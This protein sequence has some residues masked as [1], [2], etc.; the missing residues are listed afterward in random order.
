[1]NRIGWTSTHEIQFIHSMRFRIYDGAI[2]IK[3][4]KDHEGNFSLH[5]S[6]VDKYR[7]D[8]E[9]YMGIPN[10]LN[11]YKR[12]TNRK[13]IILSLEKKLFEHI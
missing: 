10:I 2:T 3:V 12:L 11:E 5:K 1:M 9:I 13:S 4:Y 8:Y 6:I 7:R